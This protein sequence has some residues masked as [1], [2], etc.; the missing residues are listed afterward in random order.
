MRSSLRKYFEKL[1]KFLG[2]LKLSFILIILVGILIAQRAIIA[3]KAVLPD[4]TKNIPWILKPFN[5]LGITSSESLDILFLVVMVFFV[6]NLIFSSINMRQKIQYKQ[7]LFRSF[8][9]EEAIHA[10]ANNVVLRVTGNS[11]P[12]VF[13][14]LKRHGLRVKSEESS[15]GTFICAGKRES[16]RWG[17]LFFHLTFLIVLIGALVS[18]LTQYSGYV[19]LSLG[20]VFVEKRDNYLRV[21]DKPKLFGDDKKFK[22]QLESID[23]SYWK[24]GAAKQ[25]ASIVNVFDERGIF[26]EKKR[27]Q[28]N[29]PLKI[30]GMSIYQGSR[31]GFIAGLEIIDSGGTRATGTARF[32]I[33]EKQG[34]R[35]MNWISLPGTGLSLELELFTEK[36]GEIKGLEQLGAQSM[37]TLLKVTSIEGA[38]RMFHGVVFLGSELSF[39]GLALHFLSLTPY[40]SFIIVRDYGIPIIFSGFAFLLFGLII[41]YF[42]VPENYWAVIRREKGEEIIVLGATAERY[43]ESFKEC[44]AS[45]ISELREEASKL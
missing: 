27:I 21:S 35:M 8:R 13:G 39:E 38:R 22:I 6:I 24:P 25:R 10:L 20:D 29:S 14:F 18:I 19:E 42:W 23:L 40:T 31:N 9:N 30:K 33:P 12:L 16:G 2:S 32:H 37:A 41:T 11:K 45:H 28:V 5:V 34:D 36:L 3:Q 44:F 43:R 1:I 15:S 17:V 26:I 7:K 4:D